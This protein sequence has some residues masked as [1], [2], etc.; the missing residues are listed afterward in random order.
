V[1]QL[2]GQSRAPDVLDVGTLVRRQGRP[3]GPPGPVQGGELERHPGRGQGRQRRLVRRLRRLRGHRLQ[4]GKVKVPAD[5]VQAPAQPDL[6]ERGRPQRQPDAGR[7]GL[8]RRLRRGAGQRRLAQQHRAR[9]QL[10]QEA[11]RSGQLRAGD[12]PAPTTVESGQTPILIWWDYLLASEVGPSR[13]RLEDRHPVGRVTT[14]PTTT[15]PS[16]PRARPGRRPAVGGVPVLDHRP[17]PLAPGLGP[18]DR[19]A[20][21]GEGRH[22]RTR[23]PTR[24]CRRPRP[25]IT[26][27]TQAQQ[28]GGREPRR[29]AVASVGG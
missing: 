16:A 19:A 10:L 13:S 14:P 7:R 2:K 11:A 21:P 22:G 25:A 27:P 29:P 4:L 18:A 24:R 3:G 6:Q 12:R 15:R 17:E 9:H 5:V 8:R 1:S 28:A 20:D 23:P 26:F